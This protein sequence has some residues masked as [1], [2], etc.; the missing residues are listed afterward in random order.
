MMI[1]AGRDPFLDEMLALLD[2]LRGGRA[3]ERRLAEI[4]DAFAALASADARAASCAPQSLFAGTIE[5][6]KAGETPHPL[7]NPGGY[8]TLI[9]D[10]EA[11]FQKRVQE[12]RR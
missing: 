2:A 12:E 7:L 5:R 4:N 11:A 3:R 1:A 6:I 8:A 9:A 10:T